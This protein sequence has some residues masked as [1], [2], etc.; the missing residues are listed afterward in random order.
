MFSTIGTLQY[1]KTEDQNSPLKLIRKY[2]LRKILIKTKNLLFLPILKYRIYL[3]LM[4]RL[5]FSIG[6]QG[7]G[8]SILT[9]KKLVRAQQQVVI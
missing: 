9:M 6:C 1:L 3:T 7:T 8:M 5:Y 2:P 4:N